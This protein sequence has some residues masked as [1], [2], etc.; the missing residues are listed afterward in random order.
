MNNLLPSDRICIRDE[1]RK[2]GLISCYPPRSCPALTEP[3][4]R[5]TPFQ[6]EP[7]APAMTAPADDLA[8]FLLAAIVDSS[9][10]AI[11]S[12]DLNG[13]VMSWNSAAA[14]MFGYTE[15]EI[16]GQSILLLIPKE[17]H[18]DEDRIL[19]KIRAGERIEHYETKRIKKN[20]ERF[21]VSATI[22]PVRDATGRVIG[23]SKIAR[24]ISDRRQSD[25]SRVRLAAIVDSADDA[26]ISKDLNGIISSWNEG[27]PPY[28]RV[29]CRGDGRPATAAID[30]KRSPV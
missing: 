16:V 14:R 27:A 13:I 18:P 10:D 25:E 26:I 2:L 19:E 15:E 17:L 12:K 11:I 6:S 8:R 21:E 24:D 3:A 29:H 28:V 23:A 20:G 22:S 1:V 30:T 5:S 9:D 4:A 7:D